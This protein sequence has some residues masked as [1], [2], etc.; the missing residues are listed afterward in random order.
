V[1]RRAPGSRAD[2]VV[3]RGGAQRQ[4]S[5]T[6]AEQEREAT[7]KQEGGPKPEPSQ[8]PDKLGIALEDIDA[9][10]A[11]RLGLEP[12]R[13]VIIARVLPGS[14]AAQAGLR[15]G[16]LLEEIGDVDVT[17]ARQAGQAIAQADL[18]EGVRVR[19]ERGGMGQYVFIQVR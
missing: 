1:A 13:G 6:V 11:R 15:P 7:P 2:L 5:V 4:V 14:P 17:S 8:T 9:N 3:W 10:T 18:A 16:D 19:V 12:K